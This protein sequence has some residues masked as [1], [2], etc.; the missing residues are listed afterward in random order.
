VNIVNITVAGSFQG[1]V[2][3]IGIGQRADSPIP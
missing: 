2:L 3:Q 1:V